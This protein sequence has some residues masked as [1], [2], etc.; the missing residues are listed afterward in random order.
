MLAQEA[1]KSVSAKFHPIVQYFYFDCRE[2]LPENCYDLITDNTRFQLNE[3]S[4]YVA[5][6]LVFGSDFQRKLESIKCFLVGSGALGC[7]YIKNFAM[8]GLCL[9]KT[10]GKLTVTGKTLIFY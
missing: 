10:N 8:V 1:I 6:E 9:N 4:R 7:E 5:Q 2:C 3:S